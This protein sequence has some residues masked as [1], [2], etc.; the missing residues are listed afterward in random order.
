MMHH[1]VHTLAADIGLACAPLLGFIGYNVAK[2]TD[3]PP[4]LVGLVMLIISAFA[5]PVV[6]WMMKRIDGDS[7]RRDKREDALQQ[8]FI[9]QLTTQVTALTSVAQNLGAIA[10]H[11]GDILLR[12]DAKP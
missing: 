7:K 5:V 8:A 3:V 11:L 6:R 1:P 12:L 2:E 4:T 9:E 10:R